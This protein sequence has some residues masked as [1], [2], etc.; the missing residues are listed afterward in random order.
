MTTQQAFKLVYGIARSIP[1]VCAD[2]SNYDDLAQLT[3]II[4]TM[5]E[6]I[7]MMRVSR[8]TCSNV[9]EVMFMRY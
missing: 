6:S 3:E 1:R 2:C 5:F 9:A 8:Q 4:Q 7:Y